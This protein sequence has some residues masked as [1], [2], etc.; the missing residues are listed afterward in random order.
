MELRSS[1]APACACS[2]SSSGDNHGRTR[3]L[4]A[5]ILIIDGRRDS[6]R[7]LAQK[8]CLALPD[9]A[10]AL[11]T[12]SPEPDADPGLAAYSA[13]LL[14]CHDDSAAGSADGAALAE[15]KG[16]LSRPQCPPVVA[17]A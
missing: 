11:R 1:S 7:D 10:V 15:L 12:R 3:R 8:V 17:I 6:G 5:R 14:A 9:A 4:T 16:L 2:S 13:V